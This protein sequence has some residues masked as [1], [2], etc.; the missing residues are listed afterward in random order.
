MEAKIPKKGA[1]FCRLN[2]SDHFIKN[3]HAIIKSTK[4]IT[5]QLLV[6]FLPIIPKLNPIL[7]LNSQ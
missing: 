7:L 5:T 4:T 3:N 6:F 1:R 2:K